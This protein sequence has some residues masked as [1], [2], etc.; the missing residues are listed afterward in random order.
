MAKKQAIE[1]QTRARPKRPEEA[2]KVSVMVPPT[3]LKRVDRRAKAD[4]RP[5]SP[6]L[7]MLIERGLAAE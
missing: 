5:R 3:L 6:M 1:P 4:R 7:V 2:V